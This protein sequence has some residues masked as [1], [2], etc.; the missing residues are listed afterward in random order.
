MFFYEQKQIDFLKKIMFS[1]F[2][3]FNIYFSTRFILASVK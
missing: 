1:L 2:A 3:C